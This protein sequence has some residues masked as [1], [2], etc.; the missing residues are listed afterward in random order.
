MA[1]LCLRASW[2]QRDMG[3]VI[4][5]TDRLQRVMGFIERWLP[6]DT[7]EKNQA[8]RELAL[9]TQLAAEVAEGR[10]SKYQSPYVKFVLGMMW[11]RHGENL[12]F[13]SLLP[14]P[15]GDRGL[16]EALRSHLARVRDSIAKERHWQRL[17][18]EH[19]RKAIDSNAVA[20][21]NRAAASYLIGELNRRL[22]QRNRALR[23][24]DRALA[25]RGIDTHLAEW[26]R[27]QRDMV[28]GPARR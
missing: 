24:Y 9:V 3:S 25:D 15:D 11:R 12:L 6:P 18:L 14:D 23:Y 21:G 1:W 22:G 7:T 5:K 8:D 20:G 13:E 19:F 17:A 4:P 2:V 28:A 16:P 27:G 10:F 26:A